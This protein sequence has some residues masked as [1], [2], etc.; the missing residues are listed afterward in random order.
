MTRPPGARPGPHPVTAVHV[1][2]PAAAPVATNVRALVQPGASDGNERPAAERPRE[3]Q[4]ADQLSADQLLADQR[5]AG[6]PQAERPDRPDQP[7]LADVGY[8]RT[9]DTE[10]DTGTTEPSEAG[11][12]DRATEGGPTAVPPT[13]LV[14][15]PPRAVRHRY[16]IERL[17]TG[18]GTEQRRAAQ[19]NS[20]AKAETTRIEGPPPPKPSISGTQPLSARKPMVWSDNRQ[21]PDRPAADPFLFDRPAPALSNGDAGDTDGGNDDRSM[22]PTTEPQGTGPRPTPAGG[23][24]RSSPSAFDP[25][26]G[27]LLRPD[28]MARLSDS[29][30]ELLARLQAE[31]RGAPQAGQRAGGLTANGGGTGTGPQR[32]VDPPD[33]AG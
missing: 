29:G 20:T 9:A 18:A 7:A 30:R 26:S 28:S 24:P 25:L 16:L 1:P 15:P 22:A 12:P 14:P 5:L 21:L 6:Q 17:E 27:E 2:G 32:K 8:R 13:Q 10:A 3:H 31:L 4:P 11:M 33:L 23:T 19:D